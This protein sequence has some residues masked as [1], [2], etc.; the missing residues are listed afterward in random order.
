MF[1]LRV[2]DMPSIQKLLD[3]ERIVIVDSTGATV[4]AP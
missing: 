1:F 4:P 2:T 3:L